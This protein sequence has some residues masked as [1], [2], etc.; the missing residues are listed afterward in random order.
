MS[1]GI[2]FTTRGWTGA[3]V[4][5]GTGLGDEVYTVAGDVQ[6]ACDVAIDFRAWLLHPARVWAAQITECT[7][8]VGDAGDGR[9]Y[10]NFDNDAPLG[11]TDYSSAWSDRIAPSFDG[12]DGV[13][14]VTR[15]SCSVVPGTVMWER[16]DSDGGQRARVG[17]W[18]N[19]HPTLSHRQPSCEF[20]LDLRQTF[21][22]NEAVGLAVDPRT[23][24]VFDEQL[25][26]FRFVTVGK[27]DLRMHKDDDYTKVVGTL[28]ILGG[29]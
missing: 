25:N 14:G 10:F 11:W 26:D 15:G 23:A 22:M 17:S 28:E 3:H 1:C 4:T 24:Y 2:I 27:L 12:V 20:G 19:G 5:V 7:I 16:W 9:V 18:R 21:A 8:S 6:N 29:L 13:Q